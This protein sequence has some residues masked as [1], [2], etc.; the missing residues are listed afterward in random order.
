MSDDI[1]LSKN[2]ELTLNDLQWPVSEVSTDFTL[3]D[4]FTMVAALDNQMPGIAAAFGMRHFD[5]FWKKINE[6]PDADNNEKVIKYLEL[7]WSA[8]YDTR[9][10]PKT[11]DDTDQK[12]GILN[13]DNN[14][15]D[16]PIRGYL[17]NLMS[18]HG[19]GDGC[20]E[21]SFEWHECGNDCPRQTFYGVEFSSIN[22]LG[23]LRIKM[24][25]IVMTYPPFVEPGKRFRKNNFRLQIMPTLYCFIT[26]IFWELTFIG[27]TPDKISEKAKGIFDEIRDMQNRETDEGHLETNDDE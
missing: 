26:S 2:Y 3:Y 19:I 9:V 6:P 15:W 8:D 4:L 22:N 25:P 14:Y 20:P 21:H 13:D 18:F 11:G 16:N 5:T 10:V 24:N 27:N 12:G 23:H 17:P 1:V 7:Y